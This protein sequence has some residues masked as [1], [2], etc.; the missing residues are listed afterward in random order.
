MVWSR[1]KKKKKSSVSTDC[2]ILS[3]G[4]DYQ[5]KH[6]IKMI[7]RRDEFLRSSFGEP[8][9]LVIPHKPS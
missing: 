3:C 6:V 7:K 4:F 1:E 5:L 8:D 9:H 2:G